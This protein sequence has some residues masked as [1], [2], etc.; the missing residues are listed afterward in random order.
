LGTQ[1]PA[2]ELKEDRRGGGDVFS[3]AP[4]AIGDDLM[5]IAIFIDDAPGAGEWQ[6]GRD[7]AKRGRSFG[8]R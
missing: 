1:G 5:A 2:A 3:V 6:L 7:L 8:R 4:P